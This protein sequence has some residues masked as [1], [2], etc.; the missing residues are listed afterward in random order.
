MSKELGGS[1]QTLSDSMTDIQD[2]LG[3]GLVSQ[4]NMCWLFTS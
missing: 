2:N 1:L 4:L 3:G